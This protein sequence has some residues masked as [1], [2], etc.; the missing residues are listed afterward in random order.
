[1]TF[2]VDQ[3]IALWTNLAK[4]IVLIYNVGQCT[5]TDTIGKDKTD[6]RKKK[7]Y[8]GDP[9]SVV[10]CIRRGNNQFKL[11]SSSVCIYIA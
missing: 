6:S 3:S 1:M 9:G 5:A 8:D 2:I 11:K 7:N 10:R 4:R